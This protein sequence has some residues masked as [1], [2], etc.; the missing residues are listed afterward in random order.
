MCFQTAVKVSQ[1]KST[2][3]SEL[4]NKLFLQTRKAVSQHFSAELVEGQE[5]KLGFSE[6]HF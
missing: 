2:Q 1:S 5:G 6:R 4:S 3:I